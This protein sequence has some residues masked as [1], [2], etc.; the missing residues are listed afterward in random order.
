M[1]ELEQMKWRDVLRRM[2]LILG[3]ISLLFAFTGGRH[4]EHILVSGGGRHT[5]ETVI[6]IIL[7]LLLL[8][9]SWYGAR[10]FR[11]STNA[12]QPE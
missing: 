7:A 3:P 2:S 1:E 9:A 10:Q 4:Y 6:V 12:R 11:S 8:S 5:G